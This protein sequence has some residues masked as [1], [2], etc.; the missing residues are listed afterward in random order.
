MELQKATKIFAWLENKK[1]ETGCWNEKGGTGEVWKLAQSNNVQEK[2][3]VQFSTV[4][5]LRQYTVV[6]GRSDPL[7]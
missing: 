4:G 1:S 6:K 7:R 3:A 5:K 2:K